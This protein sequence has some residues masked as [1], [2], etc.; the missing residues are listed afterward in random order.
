MLHHKIDKKPSIE[1]NI[2]KPKIALFFS[3][4]KNINSFLFL[5][6]TGIMFLQVEL[7]QR[8]LFYFSN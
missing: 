4:N 8:C 7:I 3:K 1:I 6:M 5:N 2:L